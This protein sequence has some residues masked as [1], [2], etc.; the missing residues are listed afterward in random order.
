MWF[1]KHIQYELLINKAVA[2]WSVSTPNVWQK[3]NDMIES[4][5]RRFTQ[6]EKQSTAQE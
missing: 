4:A 3:T 1:S 2:V 5:I 6:N